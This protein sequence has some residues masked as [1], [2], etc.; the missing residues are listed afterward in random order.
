[1][2]VGDVGDLDRP[3]PDVGDVSLLVREVCLLVAERGLLVSQCLLFVGQRLLLIAELILLGLLGG[4]LVLLLIGGRDLVVQ[5]LDLR[6]PLGDTCVQLLIA[7][8]GVSGQLPC[9]RSAVYSASAVSAGTPAGAVGGVGGGPG[10]G[11]RAASAA[12]RALATE[13]SALFRAFRRS[14]R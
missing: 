14:A 9:W 5:L 10:F 4:R 12:L 13:S 3:G 1:M 11:T 6:L 7:T 2:H 8:I